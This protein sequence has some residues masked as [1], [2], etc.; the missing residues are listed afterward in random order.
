[1]TPPGQPSQFYFGPGLSLAELRDSSLPIV[2]TGGEK[3]A[4]ARQKS[5]KDF[6]R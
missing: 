1:M 3:K 6:R 5:R 2:I 4:L